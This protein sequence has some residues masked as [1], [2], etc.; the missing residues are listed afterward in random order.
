MKQNIL[1]KKLLVL[2][3]KPAASQDIVRM[4]KAMGVYAIVTDNLNQ[5]KSPAK[6]LADEVWDI[7]TA[8]IEILAERVLSRKIDGI[9]T[10]AHEFNLKRTKEL[11]DKCNLPFYATD[12]QLRLNFDKMYFKQKCE[13]VGIYVPRNY[14]VSYP[15]V[16]SEL[17]YIQYPVIVKPRDGGGGLGVTICYNE[18]EI[19]PAIECAL[20]NSPSGYIIVEEYI[21]GQEITAVYTIK[22]GEISLS[23]LRDRYPSKEYER[24]TSQYD[25]SLIPSKYIEAFMKDEHPKFVELFRRTKATNASV[26]FQGIANEKKITFF[27]CGYRINA[28]CDYHNMMNLHGINYLEMM[29]RYAVT[30]SMGDCDLKRENP[31]PSQLSAIFNMTAHSGIIGTQEGLE[32]VLK[33]DNVISAEYLRVV[34]DKIIDSAS[35][36]QSVFRANIFGQNKYELVNV[37]NLIQKHIVIKDV[38]GKNMLFCPFDTDRLF[39]E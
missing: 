19:R 34:G 22:D 21:V 32:E 35:M 20:E 38:E 4:A 26:F 13:E 14:L 9:F 2:G 27:E 15:L 6:L 11:C 8:D 28:L 23:C 1:G 17:A 30:G 31:F 37:I 29:I 33:L 18:S 25:L 12:E 24:I 7:S 39:N 36:A 10:G 16:E 5:E 3:G